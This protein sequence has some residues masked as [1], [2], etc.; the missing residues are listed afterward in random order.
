M[1]SGLR[2]KASVVLGGDPSNSK[3]F[4]EVSKSGKMVNAYNALLLAKNI[5]KGKITLDSNAK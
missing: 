2:S 5:S 3:P 1:Q 4:S